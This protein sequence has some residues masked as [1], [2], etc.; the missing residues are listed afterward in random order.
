MQHP[1]L[2]GHGPQLGMLGFL[3]ENRITF[4]GPEAHSNISC[5]SLRGVLQI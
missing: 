3:A 1:L 4:F 2:L 5:D